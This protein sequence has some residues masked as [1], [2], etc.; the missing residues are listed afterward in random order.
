MNHASSSATVTLKKNNPNSV[1]QTME[2][3]KNTDIVPKNKEKMVSSVIDVSLKNSDTGDDL[4]VKLGDIGMSL[5][6]KLDANISNI[7]NL[8]CSYLNNKDADSVEDG[9]ATWTRFGT[10]KLDATRKHVTCPDVNHAT[11][12]SILED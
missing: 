2:I 7:T 12:F 8:M 9:T 4:D 6:F 1:V 10:A 3:S 5:T 11:Y